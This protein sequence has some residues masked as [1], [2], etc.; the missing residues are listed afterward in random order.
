MTP[1]SVPNVIIIMGVSAAGKTEVG[2]ALAAT[3]GW[4][5]IEGD[6]YHPASNV[7]KMAHGIPLTDDD[8][9]PWLAALHHAIA[10]VA[11]RNDHAVVACS[12]L[13]HSYRE[14]LRL[15]DAPDAVRFVYLDVPAPILAERLA[16]RHGHFMPPSL[17]ESQ[18]ET[19]EKPRD[20]LRVDGTLPVP[21]IVR[22]IVDH[23]HLAHA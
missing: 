19:L 11:T 18:L 4:R 2:R 1:A 5:L 13:K 10:D 3:V 7:E 12:A 14:R 16:H 15:S 6:D 20:A 22:H 9:A 17:L 8:R 23:F 21:E